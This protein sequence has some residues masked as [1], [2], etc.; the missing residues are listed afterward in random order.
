MLTYLFIVHDNEV[1]ITRMFLEMNFLESAIEVFKNEKVGDEKIIVNFYLF[2][3]FF[4]IVI[5]NYYYIYL[6]TCIL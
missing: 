4:L 5:W 6:H 2:I 1:D 3:Y